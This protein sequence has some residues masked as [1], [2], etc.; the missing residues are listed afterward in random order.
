M[1]SNFVNEMFCSVLFVHIFNLQWHRS[2]CLNYWCI[3]LKALVILF[4]LLKA[5]SSSIFWL[6]PVLTFWL[7]RI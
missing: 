1:N 5:H 7:K 6:L 2:E 3:T 4:P